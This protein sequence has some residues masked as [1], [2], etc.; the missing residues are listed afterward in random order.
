MKKLL[1]M[2]LMLSLLLT[3]AACAKTEESVNDAITGYVP[4]DSGIGSASNNHYTP[5]TEGTLDDGLTEDS[6]SPVTEVTTYAAATTT[7]AATWAAPWPWPYVRKLTL[8]A[9][10]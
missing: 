10:C 7:A 6:T 2:F 4:A 3:M 5:D 1:C 8:P 9:L